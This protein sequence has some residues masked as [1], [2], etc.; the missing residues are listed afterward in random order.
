MPVLG[1]YLLLACAVSALAACAATGPLFTPSDVPGGAALLYVYRP[2]SQAL[3]G[4]TAAIEVDGRRAVGLKNNGYAVIRL[5]PGT[6]EITQRWDAWLG[7]RSEL[8]EARSRRIEFTPDSMTC[9]RLTTQAVRD[10]GAG[11]AG[12]MGVSFAWQLMRVPV[13]DAL[14][15][16]S[17]TRRVELE[18]GFPQ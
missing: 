10:V 17:R 6:Y 13:E 7:D 18:P 1:R 5:A 15:E 9:L 11:P 8:R 12:G 3:G 4:R 14:P 2:D 16:L